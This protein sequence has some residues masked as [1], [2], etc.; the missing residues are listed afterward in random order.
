MAHY[1][2]AA[3]EEVGRQTRAILD[4]G[5]YD[6]PDGHRVELA[7]AVEAAVEGTV[8]IRAGDARR[9]LAEHGARVLGGVGAAAP[10]AVE[11]TGETSQ[12]AL[13]RLAKE[14]VAAPLLLNFASAV[15]PG[16]GFLK[17]ARA[18]E[19]DLARCS[20]LYPCLVAQDVPDGFYARHRGARDPLYSDAMIH[21]P[22]V[23]FFRERSRTL[24]PAPVPAA[25][26]TVAAPDGRKASGVPLEVAYRKRAGALLAVSAAKGHRTLILG[27]WGCGVF[28]CEP[29]MAADAFGKWLEGTFAGVFERVV[30]PVYDPKP[31]QPTRRVF[32][33]RLGA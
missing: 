14:G 12:Q 25:V 30:F 8:T 28:R 21:S 9:A 22:G 6:H 33:A 5:G 7:A 16:G 15:K 13:V 20:A 17:G 1:H 10:T 26:L 11:V 4:A 24:L 3:L 31:G 19:E 27:A 18:Q 32:E 23:P 2:D 29:A